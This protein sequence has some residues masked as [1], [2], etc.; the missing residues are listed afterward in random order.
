VDIRS[1]TLFK[2]DTTRMFINMLY[3]VKLYTK[4]TITSYCITRSF[5][6]YNIDLF[7]AIKIGGSTSIA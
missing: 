3:C 4:Y 7:T 2:L 5:R 1:G 6:G